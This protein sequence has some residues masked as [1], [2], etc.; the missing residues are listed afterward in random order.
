MTMIMMTLPKHRL[1]RQILFVAHWLPFRLKFALTCSVHNEN[2]YRILS[3]KFVCYLLLGL[4]ALDVM[5][6]VYMHVH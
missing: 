2:K 1:H 5:L 3:I 4:H 6:I